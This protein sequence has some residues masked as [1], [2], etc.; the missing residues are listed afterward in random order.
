MLPGNLL[1]LHFPEFEH[2]NP[3]SSGDTLRA[4]LL[5]LSPCW[6]FLS[7]VHRPFKVNFGVFPSP[8]S[9]ESSIKHNSEAGDELCGFKAQHSIT[10][11]C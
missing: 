6:P 3:V 8:S 10:W 11:A 4:K 7:G 5:D 9:R 1:P 2:L